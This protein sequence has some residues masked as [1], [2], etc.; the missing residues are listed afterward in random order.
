MSVRLATLLLFLCS[1]SGS[2]P[3]QE[4]PQEPVKVAPQVAPAQEKPQAAPAQEKP[5]A[6]PVQEKPQAAPVQEKPQT[7]PAQ[8]KPKEPAKEAPQATPQDAPKELTE[9]NWPRAFE[10]GG[11]KVVVYEPQIDSWENYEKL[12]ARSA[13]VVTP[14]GEK[15]DAFGVMEYEVETETQPESRQALLKNRKI[16]ALRFSGIAKD[17]AEKCDAI[18]RRIL[19]PKLNVKLSLDFILAYMKGKGAAVPSVKVNLAPPPIYTSEVPTI[20]VMFLGEP[21]FK[22]IKGTALKFA[23]NTNWDIILN[24]ATSTYYLLHG[25]GWIST[26]DLKG[27]GDWDITP[28]IP[29]EFGKLPA[30]ANWEEARKH[31]PGKLVPVPKVIVA[32]EPSELIVLDGRPQYTAIPNTTLTVV[33]N[34]QSDLFRNEADGHFYFLTS[35]RWFKSKSL[36]GPWVSA[37]ESIPPEFGKIPKDHPDAEVL[38]SV[39]GTQEAEDAVLLASVPRKAT[40]NRKNITLAVTYDGEP[41]FELIEKT[42]IS[43]AVNSPYSVFKVGEKY[44]CC[45]EAVWFEAPAPKGPWTVCDK[46]PPEIYTIPS[47]HPKYNVTY[48]TVVSSTTEEVVVAYTSGYVGMYVSYGCVMYGMGYPMYYPPYWYYHYPPYWYGYGC[49]MRYGWYGGTYYRSAAWYGPYGGAGFGSAYN[50]YTGTY[51]RGAAAYGPYGS[52]YAAS[53]YNPYTNTY[54]ARSGGSTPYSSWE[55]GVAIQ[56]DDWVRGGYYSDSRGTIAGA[57]GSGGGKILAGSNNEGDRGFVGKSQNGDIY[58]GKDG[59][60]YRKNEDGWQKYE[61]GSWNGVEKPTPGDGT[62]RADTRDTPRAENRDVPRAENRDVPKRDTPRAETRDYSSQRESY[63]SLQYQSQSR[64][65]ATQSSR[66]YSAPS[67]SYGG[68]GRGGGGRGG[69][70]GT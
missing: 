7:A 45:Y 32:T 25:E 42:T 37:T 40:V 66:Q 21:D 39:P 17:K 35:G 5:Q 57:E 69:R 24:T 68:G 61:N 36:D 28:T 12:V 63:N 51:S 33:S 46:V 1:C 54:K 30:D 15:A 29:Y 56:G 8:E 53:S 67:R 27:K 22:D 43:Y 34:T 13:I 6:A 49:S 38:A 48:V 55:R 65:R 44:Y 9:L 70:C 59:N 31:I 58:A 3:A 11:D 26:K 50:P 64:E 47:T 16:T 62:P 23:T 19:H 2:V 52:R 20:L 14:S 4:K 10:G 60:V 41:K 18:V